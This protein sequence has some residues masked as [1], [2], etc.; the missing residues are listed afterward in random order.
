[1]NPRVLMLDRMKCLRVFTHVALLRQAFLELGSWH[2]RR[3]VDF[4]LQINVRMQLI[5][6]ICLIEPFTFLLFHASPRQ[7]GRIQ[8]LLHHVLVLGD[9]ILIETQ[10]I[11][12][13]IRLQFF[14]KIRFQ[15]LIQRRLKFA[16][17]QIT[18]NLL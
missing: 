17:L 13:H 6:H 1:M 5:R 16:R 2:L 18:A 7:S 15:S 4:C 14:A 11:L 9:L 12:W 10:S 8:R 3:S